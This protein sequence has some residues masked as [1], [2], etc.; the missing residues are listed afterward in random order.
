MGSA[1]TEE[2]EREYGLICFSENWTNPLLWSHY[3]DKHRGICLGF[4]VNIRRL[5]KVT[6]VKERPA[7]RL[8]LSTKTTDDLLWTKFWDGG[9]RKSGE[10]GWA[11][12]A[13]AGHYFYYFNAQGFI[14]LREVIVGPLCETTET[15]IGAV[16]QGYSDQVEFIKARLA[17]NSFKVVIKQN[18]FLTVLMTVMM[19]G[20]FA[21]KYKMS[22]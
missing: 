22:G 2:N 17:F 16:L 13:E 11:R 7:L 10:P 3:A 6:Y 14:R 5:R 8:P 12:S 15:E 4:D 1:R 19:V 9:T 18:R 20:A 21:Q